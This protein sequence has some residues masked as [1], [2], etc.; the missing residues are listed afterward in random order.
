VLG[1]LA[2]VAERLRDEPSSEPMSEKHAAANQQQRK[3]EKDESAESSA[4]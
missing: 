1:G 3:S 4:H 2:E